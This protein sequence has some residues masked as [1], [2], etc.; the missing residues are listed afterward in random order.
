MAL[1]PILT[2]DVGGKIFKVLRETI[3]K[4]PTSTVALVIS[5]KD[6]N[7]LIVYEGTYFFDRNPDYFSVILD[8]LRTGKLF[9]NKGLSE[10]QFKEELR[11]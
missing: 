1:S 9:I 3:M 4:F 5:G 2:L 11:F 10:E 6:S 8:Y 7:N